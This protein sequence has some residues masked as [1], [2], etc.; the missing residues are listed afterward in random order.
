MAENLIYITKENVRWDTIAFLAYGDASL[1]NTIIAANV[2]VDITEKLPGGIELQI[3]VI[4]TTAL[5]A[6]AENLPPWKRN[7]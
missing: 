5:P 3:P 6:A 1:M 4:E 2:N 7:L